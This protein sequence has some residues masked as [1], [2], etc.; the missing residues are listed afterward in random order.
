MSSLEDLKPNASV[1]GILPTSLARAA[2][3]RSEPVPGLLL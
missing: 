2:P 3:I 1:R